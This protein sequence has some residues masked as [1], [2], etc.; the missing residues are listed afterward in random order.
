MRAVILA[1]GQGQRL[2][3]YTTVL[4]KPLMPVGDRPILERVV[5]QLAAAGF[6]RMTFAVGYLSHLIEAFF[7]DGDRFGVSIDYSREDEPLGTAGPLGLIAPPTED[8]LLMNGDLLTDIDYSALMA[9]HRE[10]GALATLAVYSKQVE[11]SL[12]VLKLGSDDAVVGYTEKPTVSY[13]VSTGIYCF[14][15][16]VIDRVVT[17]E[18]LDLP[19]LIHRIIEEGEQVKAY[20]FSG[21]WLDIGRPEDYQEALAAV[22]EGRL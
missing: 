21:Y 2:R 7:G 20:R 15:P 13:P 19:Q 10:S 8:F 6:D 18:R 14:R 4:P 12:G 9:S 1:G 16:D 11:I 3:P 5:T 22:E 17:G